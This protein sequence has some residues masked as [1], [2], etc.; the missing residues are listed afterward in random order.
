[1]VGS[2]ACCWTKL[3]VRLRD[4]AL[5]LLDPG[6][7]SPIWTSRPPSTRPRRAPSRRQTAIG[8]C[9]RTRTASGPVSGGGHRGGAGERRG[10]PRAACAARA[11]ADRHAPAGRDAHGARH[12]VGPGG[13]RDRARRVRVRRAYRPHRRRHE[14]QPARAARVRAVAWNLVVYVWLLVW[15]LVLRRG[16]A[17]PLRSLLIRIAAVRGGGENSP[18]T[19]ARR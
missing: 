17:G 2:L 18:A 7:D 11:R 13:R 16:T 1:M 3:R 5:G 4:P 9:G 12:P 8:C 19:P 6:I 14:H 10:V 15:L